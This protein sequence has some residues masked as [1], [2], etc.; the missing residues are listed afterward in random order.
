MIGVSY[1]QNYKTAISDKITFW[2]GEQF[3]L[4]LAVTGGETQPLKFFANNSRKK[5]LIATE[6][7]VPP[8]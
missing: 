6:L 5:R 7:S 2:E 8:S 1:S 3:P 4:T